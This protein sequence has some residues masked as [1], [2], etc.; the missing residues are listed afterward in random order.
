MTRNKKYIPI[1]LLFSILAGCWHNR[2][3]N[4]NSSDNINEENEISIFQEVL[5]DNGLNINEKLFDI[6]CH[7]YLGIN[8]N[9]LEDSGYNSILIGNEVTSYQITK[10]ARFIKFGEESIPNIESLKESLLIKKEKPYYIK[11]LISINK[12]LF[13]DDYSSL[14]YFKKDSFLAMDMV[15]L[16]NYE[17]NDA[18]TS[19]GLSYLSKEENEYPDSYLTSILWYNDQTR[20]EKIRKKLIKD[21]SVINPDFVDDLA[22][23]MATQPDLF[24]QKIPLQQVEQ[25]LAYIFDLRLA[26]SDS[27][28][29]YDSNNKGYSLLNNCYAQHEELL[30]HLEKEGYYN[31]PLLR[32]YSDF[33][34]YF[35]RSLDPL[36]VLKGTIVD[37]DGYTNIRKEGKIDAEIIQKINSG[38]KV[39]II[40]KSKD[41]YYIQTFHG[42][43]GYIHKSRITIVESK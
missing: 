24:K 25:T 41:W 17:K 6:K 1:I 39:D 35:E 42:T 28:G 7:E 15:T 38:E 12:L 11:D 40:D 9:E 43:T 31:Y 32:K 13:Y 33:Y 4:E 19:I 3:H 16:F 2:T 20:S 10:E 27:F 14:A 26:N 22:Y 29:L 30:A 37:P 23:S 36:P 34:K 21:L 5:V 18:L 8:A